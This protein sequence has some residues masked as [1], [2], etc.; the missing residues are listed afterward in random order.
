MGNHSVEL[1]RDRVRIKAGSTRLPRRTVDL[2]LH[3]LLLVVVPAAHFA[4]AC[5]C[6]LLF[7]LTALWR[8]GL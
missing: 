1:P 6:W 3:R 5:H 8:P 7:T 2:T 4:S